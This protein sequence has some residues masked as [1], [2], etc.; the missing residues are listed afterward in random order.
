MDRMA[1]GGSVRVVWWLQWVVRSRCRMKMR[2]CSS[3]MGMCMMV[4]GTLRAWHM[5]LARACS[6]LSVLL[7]Q[8]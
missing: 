7:H 1:R 8:H 6:W 3:A 4:Q 5:C 2:S